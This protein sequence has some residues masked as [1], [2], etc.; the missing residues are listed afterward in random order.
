MGSHQKKT[1]AVS[2]KK[3]KGGKNVCAK[4]FKGLSSPQLSII[5]FREG[6]L[7]EKDPVRANEGSGDDDEEPHCKLPLR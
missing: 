2:K 7:P 4:T 3:E 6:R 5:H 1:H